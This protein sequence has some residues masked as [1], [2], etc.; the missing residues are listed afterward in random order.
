M[1][2]RI[3]WAFLKMLTF[4]LHVVQNGYFPPLP[5]SGARGDF[6]LIFYHGGAPGDKTN[7]NMG[8]VSKILPF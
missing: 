7:E 3:L 5:I 4:L 2:T 8:N 6:P 1:E